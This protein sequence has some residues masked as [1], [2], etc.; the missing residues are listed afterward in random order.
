[1][2][3][4]AESPMPSGPITDGMSILSQ[5]SDTALDTDAIQTIQRTVW[6]QAITSAVLVSLALIVVGLIAG[7]VANSFAPT[8]AQQALS[9]VQEQSDARTSSVT[10]GDRGSAA[11]HWSVALSSA[12]L[13]AKGLPDLT[14]EQTFV[15]W[16]VH[17]GIIT[18]GGS[19][20][21]TG[22]DATAVATAPWVA[23]DSIEVTVEN[24]ERAKGTPPTSDA[25]FSVPL[26]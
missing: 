13:E 11:V 1:M 20:T 19:F 21:P 23:G 24:N 3:E 12:V 16:V 26:S 2:T 25:L 15:L 22:A 10:F 5:P 17:D 9:K 6:I 18:D 7:I 4:Q 14:S 8:V